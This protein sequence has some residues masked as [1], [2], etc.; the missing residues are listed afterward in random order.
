MIRRP[1]VIVSDGPGDMMIREAGSMGVVAKPELF[2]QPDPSPWVAWRRR[3]G[4]RWQRIGG[5]GS[6]VD[7][8]TLL[9]E[10]MGEVRS[11]A[12]DSVVLPAGVKP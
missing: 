7:A 5:A 6:E 12:F 1:V 9:Y 4:E 3:R 2:D 10:A 8:W 11:G